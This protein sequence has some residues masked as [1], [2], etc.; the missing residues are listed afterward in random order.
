MPISDTGCRYR[1]LLISLA[2]DAIFEFVCSTEFLL[3]PA[4]EMFALP[5]TA[6]REICGWSQLVDV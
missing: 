3:F 4:P 1:Y 6:Y 2:F 5:D